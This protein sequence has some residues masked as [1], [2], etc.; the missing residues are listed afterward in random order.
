VE[1]RDL[2]ST[3][4][5]LV[6]GTKVTHAELHDGSTVKIGHTT[7]TVRLVTEGA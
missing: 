4:G 6:D 2:G 5:M 3:N 1:V 7:M